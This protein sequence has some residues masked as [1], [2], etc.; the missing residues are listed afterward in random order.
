MRSI[1]VQ[2]SRNLALDILSGKNE[3]IDFE[4]VLGGMQD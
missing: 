1:P 4:D 2:P 3:T